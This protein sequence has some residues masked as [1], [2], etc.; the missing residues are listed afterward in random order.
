MDGFMPNFH[1]DHD[2]QKKQE[3]AKLYLWT[4]DADEFEDNRYLPAVDADELKAFENWQPNNRDDDS[5]LPGLIAAELPYHKSLQRDVKD[6]SRD[7]SKLFDVFVNADNGSGIS[8]C[9]F[10]E[11]DPEHVLLEA[12]LSLT[13]PITGPFVEVK[14]ITA[15][16]NQV[17]NFH[18]WPGKPHPLY[19][20]GYRY[21]VSTRVEDNPKIL[22]LSQRL[23]RNHA[24][25]LEVDGDDLDDEDF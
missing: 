17:D 15:M 12:T 13:K 6:R 11:G 9:M 8:F 7:I 14:L 18:P 5:G 24:L 16:H 20:Q 10:Y 3:T 1:S 23:D 22:R 2:L 4:Y 21:I 25:G 19:Q